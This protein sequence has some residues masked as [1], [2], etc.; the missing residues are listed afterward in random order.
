MQPAHS[1]AAADPLV[2]VSSSLDGGFP[3]PCEVG[4]RPRCSRPAC[5]GLKRRKLF[6]RSGDAGCMRCELVVTWVSCFRFVLS[7]VW[8]LGVEGASRRCGDGLPPGASASHFWLRLSFS[9]GR[10][11]CLPPSD[12]QLLPALF[13]PVLRAPPWTC[14]V[15]LAGTGFPSIPAWRDSTIDP[16]PTVIANG[17]SDSAAVEQPIEECAAAPSIVAQ[18]FLLPETC[19]GRGVPFPP[20]PGIRQRAFPSA[21]FHSFLYSLFIHLPAPMATRRLYPRCRRGIVLLSFDYIPTASS[22][23][24]PL[25]PSVVDGRAVLD[26]SRG[27]DRGVRIVGLATS[28]TRDA[29]SYILYQHHPGMPP[30]SSPTMPCPLVTNWSG[31]A[32]ASA[33]LADEFG[34][35]R[36]RSR[37]TPGLANCRTSFL[38]SALLAHVERPRLVSGFSVR[39]GSGVETPG[40]IL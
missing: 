15:F 33:A 11:Y 2:R 36:G 30:P 8:R 24:F 9:G 19:W 29:T 38:N 20:P 12:G 31:G 23:H 35:R 4:G 5:L 14:F 18:T 21:P 39:M 34:A 32:L 27:R 7:G 37:W 1:K 13:V 10:A 22:V 3:I 40:W 6:G 25:H 28:T 17:P 16:A 26:I